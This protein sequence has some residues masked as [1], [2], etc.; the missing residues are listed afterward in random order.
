MKKRNDSDI[1]SHLIR[2][3]S[4]ML[5]LALAL[6]V[7]PFAL[8]QRNATKT[9]GGQIR[10]PGQGINERKAVSPADIIEVTNTNDSGPGSLRDALAVA[11]DGDEITFGVTGTIT[12]TSGELLVDK[13]IT[14]SGPGADNLA[15]DG[16]AKSRVFHIGSGVT[17]VLSGL[18]ITNGHVCCDFGGGGIFNDHGTLT[19][20]ACTVSDNSA[21]VPGGGI[22]NDA[23]AGEAVLEVTD[24]TIS[25]NSS[26]TT[27]GASTVTAQMATLNSKS[28]T[29]RWTVIPRIVAAASLLQTGFIG[30]ATLQISNTTFSE[31]SATSLGGG[32]HNVRG[33]GGPA[34]V[35]LAG[36]IFKKGASGE[37]VVNT[38]GTITSLG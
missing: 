27:G 37:N 35:D 13:S 8:A 38:S 19:V 17:V 1:K 11:N 22:Y 34:S 26:V 33:F 5:L 6:G 24:S 10:H 20:E 32:I 9:K 31:N 4:Y 21:G 29:A 23:G 28:S 30:N 14:I 3:A 25:G 15:V 36:V 2:T 7:I 18:T 12:L 16:N